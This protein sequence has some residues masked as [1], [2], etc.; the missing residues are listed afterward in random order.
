MEICD[1]LMLRN[2]FCGDPAAE[3]IFLYSAKPNWQTT[4]HN[5]RPGDSRSSRITLPGNPNTLNFV[6]SL[7]GLL[8]SDQPRLFMT[9]PSVALDLLFLTDSLD[10]TCYFFHPTLL[11][12]LR[13]ELDCLSLRGK[14][15]EITNLTEQFF[16]HST[17]PLGKILRGTRR[18]EGP[19]SH[20][21]AKASPP[22]WSV[23]M[24]QGPRR[25]HRDC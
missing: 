16:R 4:F 2:F 25:R 6:T 23:S 15:M 5:P 13:I 21:P 19:A 11:N 10:Y 22:P 9:E 14:K 20:I 24:A 18:L 12:S 8:D 7:A 1:Q 3:L 17:G